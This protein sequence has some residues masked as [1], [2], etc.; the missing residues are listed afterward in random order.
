M[1]R[2]HLSNDTCADGLTALAD[3]KAQA[4]FHRDRRD[5][6]HH[7]LDVVP[8]HHHLGARRQ[9]H[10]SGH[11][12]GAKVELR[13]IALEERRVAPA[14]LHT[15]C[16]RSPASRFVPRSST[17]TLSPACPSSK[18]LRNISTPVHVVFAVGR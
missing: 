11:I 9:L 2:N 6:L 5:Q 14:F 3:G 12:G 16:P 1:L 10:R 17:P 4:L 7:D 15:P 13:P 18:S 8:G